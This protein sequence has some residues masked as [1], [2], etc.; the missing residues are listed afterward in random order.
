MARAKYRI[1]RIT[2][3]GFRRFTNPQTICVAGKNT[4]VFGVNGQ[5]KSSIIEAI[6]WGLFGSPPGQQDIE[7]R[8]NYYQAGECA[9]TIEL[10]SDNGP[11]EIKRELRP[12]S[13]LSRQTIRDGTGKTVL[14]KDVLP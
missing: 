4:F 6:R 13:N 8:N 12:G 3:E 14:E 11:L 7:L 9:V 5:G 2:V 1:S 10:A